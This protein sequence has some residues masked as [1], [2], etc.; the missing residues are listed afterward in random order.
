M[1]MAVYFNEGFAPVCSY[2]T[3]AGLLRKMALEVQE[4]ANDNWTIHFPTDVNTIKNLLVL[5]YQL[6]EES[7]ATGTK[8]VYIEFYQPVQVQGLSVD[9]STIEDD[10]DRKNYYYCEVV[11]GTGTYS[12]PTTKDA[13]GNYTERGEWE[14]DKGSV[15][16]R[17]SWFKA[18]TESTIKKW[19]P[20][21]F[22][23]SI[24][25][26]VLQLVLA[27]DASANKLD[28][29]ISF[30]YF[31]KIKPFK[32]SKERW[33]SNFGISVGSDVPPGEYLTLEE[34]TRYSDKTG[35]GV[36]D[37]NMLETYTGFP[38][39]AH[40]AAFTT[41]DEFVDKKLEGPSNYTDKYH[42]SPVYVFH[43]FDGYRGELQGV[44][45]TDRSTVVNKDDLIHKYNGTTGQEDNPDTQ[46]I[47]KV[48]LVNAPY[49][50]LTNATN[51]MYG[52]AILKK[53]EPYT[54]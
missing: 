1:K 10:P 3:V 22:W 21:Q 27:G 16:S 23:V 20:I 50:L 45:A 40:M 6:K 32:N 44:V 2:D 43:G 39:Q 29:I 25:D 9:Q 17:F 49:S 5:R 38:M 36:T 53:T 7:P 46:D 18:T 28:R 41:P 12:E 26:D 34:R 33:S 51:V 24:T 15:R 4:A 52:L 13:D 30:G 48:F 31:G 42:M 19:L 35:T 47:Y 11:Y 37:I 14:E 54:P 8:D